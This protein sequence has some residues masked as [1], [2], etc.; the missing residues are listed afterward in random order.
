MWSWQSIS[1]GSTVRPAQFTI[2]ASAGKSAVFCVVIA[3][4][5]L[6]STTIVASPDG[7]LPVPS[8]SRAF[9]RTNIASLRSLCLEKEGCC[10]EF[11]P[12]DTLAASRFHRRHHGFGDTQRDRRWA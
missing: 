4:I 2:L 11:D 3:L 1:P 5:L 9:L 7:A 8:T 10:H 12:N 6:P